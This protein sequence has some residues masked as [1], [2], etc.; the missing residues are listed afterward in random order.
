MGTRGVKG[1]LDCGQEAAGRGGGAVHAESCLKGGKL[2][3]AWENAKQISHRPVLRWVICSGGN[4][5]L[6]ECLI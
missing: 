2:E 3:T 6:E 1:V 5:I 4:G